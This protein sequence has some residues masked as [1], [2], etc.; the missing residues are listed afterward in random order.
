MRSSISHANTSDGFSVLHV[1]TTDLAD[2]AGIAAFRLHEGLRQLGVESRMAVMNKRSNRSDVHLVERRFASTKVSPLVDF[3]FDG[4]EVILNQLLPQNSFSLHSHRLLSSS[5]VRESSIFNL[6]AL[7]RRRRHFSADLCLALSKRA[8]VVWTLHD[9]WAFTGHCT[10]SFD[11]ERWKDACGACPTPGDPVKLAFDTTAM[12]LRFKRR[13]YAE[14]GFVVVCPSRW[15]A[16]LARASPLL[17]GKR[18]EHIPYGIDA[19][20]FRPVD[21]RAAREQLSL[22]PESQILLCSAFSFSN[23]RKGL[24]FVWDAL[25]RLTRPSEGL[26]LI[27][28]DGPLPDGLPRGWSVRRMGFLADPGRQALVYAAADVLAFPSLADNLPNTVLEAMACGTPVLAFAVGGIPEIVRSGET[29][30]LAPPSDADGLARGMDWL[31]DDGERLRCMQRE[32]AA[33]VA[34]IYA[35]GLQAQRYRDLY[36]DLLG[37]RR[38]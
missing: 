1:A 3:A 36:L 34:R 30:Y 2:G 12:N 19:T 10:Y 27:M 9:M 21:K 29:G 28:G 37:Q 13:T 33:E 11:C 31:F 32:A 35:P 23:R 26:L 16:D 7:H 5:L 17:A 4:V 18:I 8:P 14:S 6:H 15:L 20:V 22:P 38:S 24:H 25:A